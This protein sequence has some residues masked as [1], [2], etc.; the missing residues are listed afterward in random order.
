MTYFILIEQSQVLANI[1]K[2]R[3]NQQRNLQLYF[4]D[5]QKGK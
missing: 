1:G 2:T 4:E 5:F 3:H